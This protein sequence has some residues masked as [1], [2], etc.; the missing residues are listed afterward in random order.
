M[1]I[2]APGSLILSMLLRG[3]PSLLNRKSETFPR[4]HEFTRNVRDIAVSKRGLT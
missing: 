2:L 4:L 3:S 1:T